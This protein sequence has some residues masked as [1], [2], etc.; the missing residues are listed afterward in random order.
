[1]PMEYTRN[2]KSLG[3][4]SLEL[5]TETAI[6]VISKN[7]NGF[8]LMVC[9]FSKINKNLPNNLVHKYIFFDFLYSQANDIIIILEIIMLIKDT[10]ILLYNS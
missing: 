10:T 1:M 2:K 8:F 4:P 6:K 3:I 5:M 7:E 9:I